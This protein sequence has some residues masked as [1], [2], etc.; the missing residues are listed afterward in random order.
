VSTKLDELFLCRGHIASQ[1]HSPLK[2]RITQSVR[3]S[4]QIP[5]GTDRRA[6]V[7][8]TDGLTVIGSRKCKGVHGAMAAVASVAALNVALTVGLGW[9]MARYR[10][11]FAKLRLHKSRIFALPEND[12]SGSISPSDNVR[13]WPLLPIAVVHAVGPLTTAFRQLTA[14]S[15]LA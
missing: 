9:M 10:F 11:V 8:T 6:I 13:E 7:G 14:V 5:P 3:Q 15:Q 1:R 12:R 4:S 2:R